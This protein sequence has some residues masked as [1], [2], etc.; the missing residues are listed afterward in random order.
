MFL[1]RNDKPSTF[2]CLIA[3]GSYTCLF[4]FSFF[5][6]RNYKQNSKVREKASQLY[7]QFKS[8][9][10][11]TG[12]GNIKV[13]M[14]R[15][16]QHRLSSQMPCLCTSEIHVYL[17]LFNGDFQR[18]QCNVVLRPG[19][20]RIKLHVLISKRRGKEKAEIRLLA[21]N[22]HFLVAL[23]LSYRDLQTLRRVRRRENQVVLAHEPQS[24]GIQTFSLQSE[25]I[26][27]DLM[28]G[29]FSILF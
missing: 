1:Q 5:Q 24:L 9:F 20:S 15:A 11:V 27:F 7:T 25:N 28:R 22:Q 14:S 2:V 6:I 18:L 19:R 10:K 17:I 12:S 16:K 13:F 23:E 8:L 29:S 3:I 21:I 4:V 26:G